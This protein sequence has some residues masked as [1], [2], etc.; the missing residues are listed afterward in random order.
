MHAHYTYCTIDLVFCLVSFIN[1]AHEYP[2]S[3]MIN[4]VSGVFLLGDFFFFIWTELCHFMEKK[5]LKGTMIYETSICLLNSAVLM[6]IV[7]FPP[8]DYA[9]YN[10][11]YL[12]MPYCS[13]HFGR[14]FVMPKHWNKHFWLISLC[15]NWSPLIS[16]SP[17]NLLNKGLEIHD[18]NQLC[19]PD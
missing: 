5:K 16:V 17:I 11:F 8:F 6:T 14:C 9:C 4:G 13:S 10:V 3:E 1:H 7:L 2:L 15:F 19:T 12:L 18:Q